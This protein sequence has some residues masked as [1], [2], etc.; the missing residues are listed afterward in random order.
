[1]NEA[2]R[3]HPDSIDLYWIRGNAHYEKGDYDSAIANYSEAIRL[4]PDHADLYYNPSVA[5]SDKGDLDGATADYNE[6]VRL[7]PRLALRNQ[8]TGM[9][10]RWT[11]YLKGK[12]GR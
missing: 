12:L 6:A 3:L 2:V 10:K 8:K 5:R 11:D 1:L 7:N 9:R 4:K